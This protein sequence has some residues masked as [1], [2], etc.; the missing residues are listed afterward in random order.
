MNTTTVSNAGN[1][2][3]L[4][5]RPGTPLADRVEDLLARMTLEEKIGQI[6]Q[7][8]KNSITPEEVSRHTVGSVLSGGGGYPAGDNSPAGWQAMINGFKEAAVATRLGIP[9]IYG[10]DAV[11]GHNNMVGAVIFPHNIGLGAAGDAGL[12]RRIGRATAVEMAA[13]GT[14]WNFAPCL[15]VARDIR[16]GRTYEAFGEETD[17]VTRLGSAYLQGL[18]GEDLAEPT[19]ALASAKH[20]FGDG[21]T[22]WG[23][24]TTTFPAMPAAGIHEPRKFAI[25][26]GDTVLDEATFRAVHLAPYVA[27]IEAGAEVVMASFSSWNGQ[28]MHGHRYLLTDLLKGELGFSG[29]VV[30]DWAGMNQVAEDYYEAMVTSFNA[31]VDMNMVPFD[32]GRFIE[33]MKHA[34]KQADISQERLDDAVRRILAVKFRLG[35]F[36][37]PLADPALQ[38][39]VGTPEHRALGR[40]AA[41]RSAVLLKNEGGTLPLARSAQRIFVAGAWADDIGLQCGGWTI[42]W[43]GKAG[44]ITPGTTILEGL[45]AAAPAGTAIVYDPAGNFSQT[46][47][48]G[49][50]PMTADAGLVVLG[51]TPYAEG[52]GD[53][54][55]LC[56][57][58]EDI[59]LIQRMRLRCEKLVLVLVTGRPLIITEQLPLLDAVV[60]AW[61]PG[62]QGEGVADV[63]FGDVPF[64]GK[65]SF[66]WPRDMSQVP[67]G[68]AGP[69]EALFTVGFGIT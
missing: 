23:T 64:T 24:S 48:R 34:L 44:P 32:Y 1:G 22:T 51:E 13:A 27:A 6:I 50:R 67:L 45:Q 52:F 21:G 56:L 4:Y 20:Y 30:S 38:S 10:V 46:V 69:G 2:R 62:T 60:V 53:R 47:D 18:Q 3:P 35:L 25:D 9:L 49:G 41:A 63:L 57:S 68:S 17:L 61:L 11:H 26:Q 16:W 12:V 66:T 39:L 36:E 55:E 29:F 19:S 28:K 15:A 42:E 59:A 7:V 54:A 8:E 14:R 5:Q 40:E 58:G 31:G 33:V 65:L 37:Q 43:Q